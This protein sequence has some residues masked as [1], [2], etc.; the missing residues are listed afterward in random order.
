ME[1]SKIP[2]YCPHCKQKQI[3]HLFVIER[4][5]PSGSGEGGSPDAK[6]SHAGNVR[7]VN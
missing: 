3:V 5:R 2:V 7:T 4:L 6:I 1:K